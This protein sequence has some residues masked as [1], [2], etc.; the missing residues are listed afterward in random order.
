MSQF[1]VTFSANGSIANQILR[2]ILNCANQND[3]QT[4]LTLEVQLDTYYQNLIF[5][6][7]FHSDQI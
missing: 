7:N 1:F 4:T 3:W 6:E 2:A 5:H